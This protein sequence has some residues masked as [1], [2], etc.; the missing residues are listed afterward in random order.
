MKIILSD[1]ELNQSEFPEDVILERVTYKTLDNF[2]KRIEVIAIAGSRAMAIKAASMDFPEWKLFQRTSAGF[3]GVPN[4]VFASN[5]IAVATVGNVYSAPIAE[6]VIFGMLTMAK[7]L[8]NNPNNRHFKLQ[9]HYDA[10]SELL[11]KNVLILGAG[12]IGTAVAQR[13]SGFEMMIDGYAQKE[14]NRPFFNHIICRREELLK[15]LNGYDYIVSTLPDNALTRKFI[16]AEIFKQMKNTAVV[17]NVGRKDV[18]NQDDFFQALRRGQIG[19][20]VLDMFEKI[21]NPIQNKFRRLSNVIVLPGVAAISQEVN[22]RLIKHLTKNLLA[23][24]NGTEICN[25][26]NGVK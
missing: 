18:F 3:D 13:L 16:D 2:N 9:R 12:S 6:T 14:G 11:D 10:I 25:V 1:K 8:R 5:G 21:P 17:V 22:L 23:V 19:G 4:D 24:I 7:K 15:E 26:I 20:A